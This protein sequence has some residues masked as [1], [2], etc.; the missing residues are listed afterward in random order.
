MATDNIERLH[1]YQRQYLGAQDFED[2]QT[3]HRDILRRLTLAYHTWG[4]VMGLE[5]KQVTNGTGIYITPGMAI[6]GYGREIVMFTP[7]TLDPALFRSFHNSGYHTVCLQ[8]SETLAVSPQTGYGQCDQNNQFGRVAENFQVVI[9]DQGAFRDNIIVNGQAIAFPIDKTTDPNNPVSFFSRIPIKTDPQFEDQPITAPQVS[10]PGQDD[11]ILPLD[12]SIAYQEFPPDDP[13]NPPVANWLIPLGQVH[14]DGTT[15]QFGDINEVWRHYIGSVAS[16][17]LTPARNLVVR[18]RS[19]NVPLPAV[20]PTKPPDGVVMTIEGT[21]LVKRLLTAE[22]NIQLNGGALDFRDTGGSP[23]GTN[24]NPRFTIT[25]KAT[26]GAGGIDLRL[27]IGEDSDGKNRFVVGTTDTNDLF[28]VDDKGIAYLPGALDFGNVTRQMVLLWSTQNK[29]LQNGIGIQAIK[30]NP[31]SATTYFRSSNDFYWYSGGIHD[32]APGSAGSGGKELMY[33]SA[34]GSL[35]VDGPLTVNGATTLNGTL[36]ISGTLNG[37]LNINGSTD[38]TGSLVVTGPVGVTGG[39]LTVNSPANVNGPLNINGSTDITGSLVVTG[40][41]GVTGGPLT[42]NG[43]TTFNGALNINGS[44]DITGSLVVTDSVGVNVLVVNG[45]GARPLVITGETDITGSLVVTGSPGARPLVVTGETDITGPLVVTGPSITFQTTQTTNMGF[46]VT[47]GKLRSGLH[48]ADSIYG[49]PNL[50]L[51]THGS[52]VVKQG[53]RIDGLCGAVSITPGSPAPKALDVVE[54]NSAGQ[55]IPS[56]STASTSV[57]GVVVDA[58]TI[59]FVLTD[60][61]NPNNPQHTFVAQMG[62]VQCNVTVVTNT[63]GIG[64][65]INKGDPLIT[66]ST[67][68]HAQNAGTSPPTG[69]VFGRAMESQPSG[70]GKI[71]VLIMRG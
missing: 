15:G 21:L 19:T 64:G 1:Y 7:T 31:S 33:L 38:I 10:S 39:P 62:I 46:S 56:S 27:K 12:Q 25:R 29:S 55:V 63:P 5:L 54:L 35:R 8:Y 41:V 67:A 6:D 43:A 57:V 20:D 59:G 69:T 18:D 3:Y 44:T 71:P 13:T 60:E 26:G 24:T 61:P 45:T 53:F 9:R 48:D 42:V 23:D 40:P 14:W 50:W 2:Q 66:S 51:D 28:M 32:D 49:F 58:D 65:P 22:D 16:R 68:G 70:T 17:I 47:L 36:N 11:Q 34:G 4:I 52:V 30:P 37:P